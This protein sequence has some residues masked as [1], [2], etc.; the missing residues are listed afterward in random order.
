MGKNNPFYGKHHSDEFKQRKSKEHRK[1]MREHGPVFPKPYYVEE[2][3]HSVRSK[4]E[5]EIG[6]LLKAN[7]IPYGYETKTF[8]LN[9][10]TSYTPDFIAGNN[11]IEVKGLLYDRQ[12]KKYREFN[13]LYPELKFIM[14]G[15]GSEEICD[16]HILWGEREQLIGVLS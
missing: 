4:W 6:L 12:K 14:V 9:D 16:I 7:G 13:E 8:K 3:G 2:L 10:G 5:E 15:N 11:V 1:W